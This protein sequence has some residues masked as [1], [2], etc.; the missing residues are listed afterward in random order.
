MVAAQIVR[1]APISLFF[2]RKR[3]FKVLIPR[4]FCTINTDGFFLF[5]WRKEVARSLYHTV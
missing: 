4:E 1:V 3:D 2:H 5:A